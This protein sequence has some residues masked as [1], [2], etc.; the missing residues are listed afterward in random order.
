MIICRSKKSGAESV[1]SWSTSAGH[2]IGLGKFSGRIS[3]ESAL[4]AKLLSEVGGW[5]VMDL[6]GGVGAGS[7]LHGGEVSMDSTCAN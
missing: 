7:V 3:A 4:R 5:P 2:E 1:G 6:S